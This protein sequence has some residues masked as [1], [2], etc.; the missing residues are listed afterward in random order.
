VSK[1]RAT[2]TIR[3]RDRDSDDGYWREW[4]HEDKP[5]SVLHEDEL[6]IS[7]DDH[8]VWL[9]WDLIKPGD[10]ATR[11]FI[12]WASVVRIDYEPCDC[13]ECAKEARRA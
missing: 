5:F 2:V 3:Q 13:F 6:A 11:T 9:C 1:T 12:P 4:V 10:R 8:G 7:F